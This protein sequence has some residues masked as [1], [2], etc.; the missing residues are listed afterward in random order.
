MMCP[1]CG[2]NIFPKTFGAE[3]CECN[4]EDY[5]KEIEM[6][7]KLC[8][9]TGI[10]VLHDKMVEVVQ[11]VSEKMDHETIAYEELSEILEIKQ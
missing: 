6:L 8:S 11:Y 3:V 10:N 1:N 9:E 5:I 2:K 7:K 4:H